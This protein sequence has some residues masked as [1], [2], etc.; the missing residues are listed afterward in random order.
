[1]QFLNIYI[2]IHS[3]LWRGMYQNFWP[4]ASEP[5]RPWSGTPDPYLGLTVVWRVWD[6][7]QR[8]I[9]QK[10]TT[11]RCW[12]C[13]PDWLWIPGK[14]HWLHTHILRLPA[15]RPSKVQQTSPTKPWC[16]KLHCFHLPV[17]LLDLT[18]V[19]F[20]PNLLIYGPDQILVRW[21]Y[22]EKGIPIFFKGLHVGVKHL[23]TFL[24]I[25]ADFQVFASNLAVFLIFSQLWC[26]FEFLWWRI[27]R[28]SS[29]MV[30]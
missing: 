28:E 23:K 8:D 9:L 16:A 7:C 4:G 19:F 10:S 26:F 1:M 6:G 21:R 3:Y 13:S 5:L 30:L 24:S 20:Q 27:L 15:F 22:S 12:W 17:N 11:G 25:A 18:T 2:Y 29:I 14:P